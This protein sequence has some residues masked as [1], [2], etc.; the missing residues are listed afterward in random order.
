MDDNELFSRDQIKSQYSRSD[1]VPNPIKVDFS[2]PNNPI[3]L[4]PIQPTA[5]SAFASRN[6]GGT[7]DILPNERKRSTFN[8]QTMTNILDGGPKKTR[9]RKFIES[10]TKDLDYFDKIYWS[11]PE[12][13]REHIRLYIKVHES[14]WD[15]FQPTR[16]EIVW[17]SRATINKGS[18]M[19]SFGLFVP[20]ILTRGTARQIK[21]FLFRA[22][23]MQ[24][25]GVY[26]Q[27]ELGHG[28]NVRGLETTAHFDKVTQEFIINTP[29]LSSIK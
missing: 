28:S 17:M 23:K 25:I 2:M 3:S 21:E 13:L 15:N 10:P 7:A 12:I 27:T 5:S 6:S 11:T 4:L 19:N 9:R 14:F 20:T 22:L 1:K 29:T 16:E 24:I 8:I 18:I 26:A